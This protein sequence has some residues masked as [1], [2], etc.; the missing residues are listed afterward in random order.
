MIQTPKLANPD[1]NT[2]LLISL[3]PFH[4]MF[5]TSGEQAPHLMAI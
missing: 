5:Q 3:K 1:A 2:L 4:F